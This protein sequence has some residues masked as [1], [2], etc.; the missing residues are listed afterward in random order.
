[1]TVMVKKPFLF[2]PAALSALQLPGNGNVHSL[3][4]VLV[5]FFVSTLGFL[6]SVRALHTRSATLV[7]ADDSHCFVVQAVTCT[8]RAK[9][10]MD[11]RVAVTVMHNDAPA[12]GNTHEAMFS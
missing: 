5:G 1:M 8:R 2:P 9:Q 10:R 6:H 4:E 3:S 7:G 12:S 11:G